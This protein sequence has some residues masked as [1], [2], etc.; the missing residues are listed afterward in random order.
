[1]ILLVVSL[2][3]IVVVSVLHFRIVTYCSNRM[4]RHVVSIN[5]TICNDMTNSIICQILANLPNVKL[6]FA[7]TRLTLYGRH[8][9]RNFEHLETILSNDLQA[10]FH[11]EN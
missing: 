10:L 9:S 7:K 4:L 5:T 3:H 8:I 1:M 6:N 11:F 2:Q